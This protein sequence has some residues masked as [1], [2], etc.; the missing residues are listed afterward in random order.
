M[1]K[2]YTFQY[3]DWSLG[4]DGTEAVAAKGKGAS[5]TRVRLGCPYEPVEASKAALIAWVNKAQRF[6]HGNDPLVMD[7][8]SAYVA[9]LERDG[10]TTMQIKPRVNRL[11][12]YLAHSRVSEIT[13]ELCRIIARKLDEEEF[14]E[15][16]IWGDINLLRTALKWGHE[17]AALFDR[18][19][20][21]RVWNIKTPAGRERVLTPDEVRKLVDAADFP[22]LRLFILLCILTAARHSAITELRWEHID[23]ETGAIDFTAGL[24]KST[25]ILDKASQKGRSVVF[26]VPTLRAALLGSKATARTPWVIE[27]KGSRVRRCNVGFVVI[28]EKAGL[29]EDVTPHVLRHTAA[30]WATAHADVETIARYL[31]HDDP[32]TTRGVY[33]HSEAGQTKTAA[34]AVEKKLGFGIRRIG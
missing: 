18:P 32:G 30:T 16:T 7:V 28:R 1:A 13:E 31:G 9:K 6:D 17:K 3:G 12:N 10:K 4:R 15:W 14:A 24:K 5:R 21:T 23:F 20:H 11:A 26:M 22:H 8:M 34:E 25:G 27:Y 29:G 33:I 19:A 2:V